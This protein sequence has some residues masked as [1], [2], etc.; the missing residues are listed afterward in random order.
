MIF[1]EYP[2]FL[3]CINFSILMS[4]KKIKLTN[5]GIMCCH[6]EYSIVHK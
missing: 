3:L 4:I 2:Y 6:R 1:N 5:P